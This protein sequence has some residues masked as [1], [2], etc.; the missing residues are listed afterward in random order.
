MQ[1]LAGTLIITGGSALCLQIFGLMRRRSHPAVHLRIERW[2]ERGWYLLRLDLA[3]RSCNTVSAIELEVRAPARARL[4]ERG[5]IDRFAV[6]G[7]DGVRRPDPVAAARTVPLPMEAGPA[8]SLVVK[9]I[10]GAAA[11]AAPRLEEVPADQDQKEVLLYLPGGWRAG[12][13]RLA[14]H[15]LLGH[16]PDA[17]RNIKLSL[18]VP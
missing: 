2:T 5:F 16:Q 11:N 14:L 10:F 8:G 18:E 4:L 17:R 9:E 7:R 1:W 12:N 3:N 13:V 6:P 15:Y